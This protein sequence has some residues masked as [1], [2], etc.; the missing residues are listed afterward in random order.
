[1]EYY[2]REEFSRLQHLLIHPDSD[3]SIF[4]YVS[5]EKKKKPIFEILVCGIP[6]MSDGN[7]YTH[8]SV[9]NLICLYDF[10]K[11]IQY[12][13]LYAYQSECKIQLLC[14]FGIFRCMCWHTNER[15]SIF[16]H[17]K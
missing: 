15:K 12:Q 3:F 14:T 6:H 17:L 2:F 16:P 1:M 5:F 7:N 10:M 9:M 4:Q 8:D 13:K 11:K